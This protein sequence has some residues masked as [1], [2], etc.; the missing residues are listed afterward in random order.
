ML[1]SDCSTVDKPDAPEPPVVI[2][3]HTT[4][5]T[6]NYQPP[7]HDGDAQVTGYILE[8]RT[9][10]PTSNCIR[11][12]HTPVTDLQY[13]FDNLTPAT[14]YMFRVAAVNKEGMSGFSLM[15]PRI[16]TAE[17][18]DKPD[19]PD[20][21]DV[22]GTSV[23]LQWTAPNSN[24]ADITEYIV[25]YLILIFDEIEEIQYEYV[26][27]SAGA[28]TNSLISHA[29]R[30]RLQADTEYI[31]AVSAV[32]RVGQGPWSYWTEKICTSDGIL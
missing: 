29:I 15:S 18:P 3:T 20:V 8:R 25:R 14:E 9:P 6:V 13:T 17:K 24:G 27:V 7:R 12:N 2:E 16:I 19:L 23:H 1:F 22:T 30:N 28:S 10:G 32:N 5:C 21:M 11:V 31:F 26:A 4:S